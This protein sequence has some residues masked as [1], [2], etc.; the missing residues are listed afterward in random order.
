MLSETMDT[1]AGKT[2]ESISGAMALSNQDL[3]EAAEDVHQRQDQDLYPCWA[4]LMRL[5]QLQAQIP[6]HQA[7][8]DASLQSFLQASPMGSLGFQR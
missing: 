5:N 6:L 4:A 7:G 3:E 8:V 1:I 2:R